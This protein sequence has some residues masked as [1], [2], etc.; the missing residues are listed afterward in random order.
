MTAK[1]GK[2]RMA[3]IIRESAGDDVYEYYPLGR[4][5]VRAVGVCGGRPTFKHTRIEIAGTLDRLAHGESVEE[6]VEGYEGRVPRE[7]IV[8][9]IELVTQQFISNLPHLSILE[10][11]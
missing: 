5:V 8:E 11:A 7:A 6:L 9:A 1:R 4:Y 3:K 2:S 10:P